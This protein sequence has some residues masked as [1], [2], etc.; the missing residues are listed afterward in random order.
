MF[1]SKCR[2]L[3]NKILR[4]IIYP[5]SYSKE[6]MVKSLRNKGCIVGENVV[7]FHPETNFIDTTRPYL[8]EIGD[9][10]K[11]TRGVVILT[12][13]FSFSIFRPVFHDNMNECSGKTIIGRNNF[14][15]MGGVILPGVHLGDNVIVG[16]GSVVTKS[17]PSNVV[18]AGNPAKVICTLDDFYK[19]R[20]D[21]FLT[22]A[23]TQ[24]NLIRQRYKR[25]PS[26]KEME[27]FYSLFM[28]RD[29][30]LL[31]SS[32]VN[33]RRSGDIEEEIIK[34]FMSSEPVFSSFEEFLEQS[35]K[36]VIN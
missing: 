2:S 5:E 19:K 12:H 27:G 6:T 28:P 31:K 30:E 18:V 26:I 36:E 23:Y 14:I 29:L 1:F 21:R 25:E 11:I 33:Y 34:D 3:I 32:G 16:S 15:G 9:G 8:L 24:A 22:D 17:F 10:A 13:D 20:K 4:R 7:F 35:K